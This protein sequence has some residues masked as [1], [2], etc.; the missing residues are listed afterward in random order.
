MYETITRSLIQFL[1]TYVRDP[2]NDQLNSSRKWCQAD[3]PRTNATFPR[4]SVTQISMPKEEAGVGR[5]VGPSTEGERF[6]LQFELGLWVHMKDSYTVTGHSG[7]VS[8]NLLREWLADQ[9][10]TAIGT[11]RGTFC[12]DNSLDD[13]NIIDSR[14]DSLDEASTI[15]GKTIIVELITTETY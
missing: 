3:Y 6:K 7:K 2:T 5:L 14:N 10:V 4:I 15:V 11:Y 8:G 1:K 13:F 9:V 12:R